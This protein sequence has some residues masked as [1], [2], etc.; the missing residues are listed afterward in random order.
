MIITLV[1]C[2]MKGQQLQWLENKIRI[3]KSS[4]IRTEIEWKHQKKS[5]KKEVRFVGKIKTK[6]FI[7][8][9]KN[10]PDYFSSDNTFIELVNFNF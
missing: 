8:K 5:P 1:T 6:L 7:K 10:M 9:I 3:G 4:T 2:F